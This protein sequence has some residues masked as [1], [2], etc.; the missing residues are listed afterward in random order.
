MLQSLS[1]SRRT[2][3][4]QHVKYHMLL[5]V[6]ALQYN[7]DNPTKP[8]ELFEPQTDALGQTFRPSIKKWHIVATGT[9]VHPTVRSRIW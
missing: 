9:T 5:H 1:C 6:G 7:I 4:G 8:L 2:D 3:Y